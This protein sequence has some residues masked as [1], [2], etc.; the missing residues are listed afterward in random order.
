MLSDVAVLDKAVSPF[1]PQELA[2]V[3]STSPWD[4]ARNGPGESAA[5]RKIETEISL[6]E[7]RC[8]EMFRRRQKVRTLPGH[9]AVAS[10]YLLPFTI[11]ESQPVAH[12]L[13]IK[14]Y[15]SLVLN[16]HRRGS[17]RSSSVCTDGFSRVSK[18]LY[19]DIVK[20]DAV[21]TK[22]LLR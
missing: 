22:E 5:R 20:F 15:A 17:D 12:P 14:S 8:I 21:R 1:S 6:I 2:A 19:I 3:A 4:R 11:V 10:A 16:N 13:R 9:S 18:V 7:V